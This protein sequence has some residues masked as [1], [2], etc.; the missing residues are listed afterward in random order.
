M[1]WIKKYR[2]ELA[3]GSLVAACFLVEFLWAWF[4][5]AFDW[6]LDV[7][8]L[9]LLRLSGWMA[10]GLCAYWSLRAIAQHFVIKARTAWWEPGLT[11]DP[12]DL[13]WDEVFQL[14]AFESTLD[15]IGVEKQIRWA[16]WRRTLI[17]QAAL[18][19]LVWGIALSAF[20]LIRD[21]A[22]RDFLLSK[23][24]P[25]LSKE[26]AAAI[27][28]PTAYLALVVGSATIFFTFRQIRAKVRA[29]S[30]Q[31]WIIQARKLL[32]EVVAMIDAHRDQR[33][34][35]SFKQA[36]QTWGKLNPAR[37]EL[38]LMLNPS[39]KDHRLLLYLIQRFASWR[40]PRQESQDARIVK[41]SIAEAYHGWDTAQA[42]IPEKWKPIIEGEDRA[43]LVSYILRLS[44]VV[45]KRE[46]ERVKHTR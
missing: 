8:E 44:H 30:R 42:S 34:S 14:V 4:F 3:T 28:N 46:W 20:D 24:S 22:P 13:S 1:E 17:L 18:Y 5:G 36:E 19:L 40:H 10:I 43:E 31:Q 16:W 45:L 29:D 12:D 37:L 26:V 32:G 15:P 27:G 38:E 35:N 7:T 21:P 23:V 2:L 9:P 39:E 11:P 6:K 25:A 33:A 41:R